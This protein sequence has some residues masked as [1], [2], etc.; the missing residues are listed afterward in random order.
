MSLIP[1]PSQTIGPFFAVLAPVVGWQLVPP[2]TIGAVTVTGTVFDG[3]GAPVPDALIE[4]WQ[5]NVTGRYAH[6]ADTQEKLLDAD[7]SG[8]GQ[9]YTDA[10]GCFRFL[11]V[12]PGE[13]PGIGDTMQAPHLT[14]SVFARGLLKR[15]ATR[16]YF[17][18]EPANERDP[19]LL[20]ISDLTIRETLIARATGAATLRFDIHLQGEQETAFFAI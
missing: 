2:G 9:C 8:F 6:P 19:V 4:V 12:K 18:G 14:V 13:V 3:A 7:F 17:A 10:D 1:T 20:S 16:M 15:L 11:T 5:A